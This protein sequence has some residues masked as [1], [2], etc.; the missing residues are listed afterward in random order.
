MKITAMVI[1]ACGLMILGACRPQSP[2]M[3]TASANAV[4]AE[5]RAANDNLLA[6]V[7]TADADRV[8][9]VYSR[10]PD[11]AVADNGVL[12]T[13]VD[14]VREVYRGIYRGFRGIAITMDTTRVAVISSNAAVMTGLGT[15]TS[16]DTAGVRQPSMRLTVTIL[17][18]RE[19][20]GW[21]VRQMHQ[22][23]AH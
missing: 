7:A 20:E 6:A 11:F 9:A 4:M 3:T 23:F 16:T 15:V 1:G 2:S 8:F 14:T 18:V 22:S 21:R 17:W 5:V 10:R 12:Y 13:S 19:P